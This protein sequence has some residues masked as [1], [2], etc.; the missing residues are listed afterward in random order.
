MRKLTVSVGAVMATLMMLP[1][2]A[3][4][5]DLPI[6]AAASATSNDT[7]KGSG[8]TENFVLSG[9]PDTAFGP[10]QVSF[11]SVANFNGTEP[12]GSM[13]A[14]IGPDTFQGDVTCQQVSGNTAFVSGI[15][16]HALGAETFAG[17]PANTWGVFAVDNGSSGD[18]LTFS[19]SPLPVNAPFG[20]TT[21]PFEGM[22][23]QADVEIHDG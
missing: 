10:A 17:A 4:A 23:E 1:L 22:F 8:T 19:L 21:G 20:C 12:R 15:V 9:S 3:M 16:D 7:A 18:E 2:P 11:S 5:S 13:K 6:G 14:T